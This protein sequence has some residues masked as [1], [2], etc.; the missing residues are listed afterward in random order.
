MLSFFRRWLRDTPPD[1]PG[2]QA[3]PGVFTICLAPDRFHLQHVGRTRQ[4][5]GYWVTSQLASEAGGTRDFVA[6][7]LFDRA[8][9]LISADVLD[10]GLRSDRSEDAPTRPTDVMLKRLEAETREEIRVQPFSCEF[11]GHG[12]GLIPREDEKDMLIDAMPGHTLMFYGP[13]DRCNYGS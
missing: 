5:N 9:A 3:E 11:Y 2:G 13:W 7:Y 1:D 10:L 4:G 6:G 8:G 12:F